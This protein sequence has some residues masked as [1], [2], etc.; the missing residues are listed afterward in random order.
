MQDIS[1]LKQDYSVCGRRSSK[2]HKTSMTTAK[3]ILHN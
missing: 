1:K 3:T 2:V